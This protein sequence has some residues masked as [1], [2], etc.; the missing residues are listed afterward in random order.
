MQ[1]HPSE[2]ARPSA[3]NAPTSLVAARR[4]AE[5][6]PARH[7]IRR[8]WKPAVRSADV[9][10]D[11]PAVWVTVGGRQREGAEMLLDRADWERI[12]SAYGGQWV[13]NPQHDG[14]QCYVVSRRRI[15]TAATPRTSKA[16]LGRIIAEAQPG[17]VVLYANGNPLDLR[18][19]NLVRLSWAEAHKWRL[20]QA[21]RHPHG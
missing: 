19:T 16:R 3:T 9:D 4:A 11:T 13:A 2:S 21:R 10:G 5:R 8:D 20:G 1:P 12:S 15:A 17:E 18:R 6:P 14:R 7:R